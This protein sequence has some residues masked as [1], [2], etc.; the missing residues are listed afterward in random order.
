MIKCVICGQYK[1]ECCFVFTSF[2]MSSTCNDCKNT[3]EAAKR[4]KEASIRVETQ[5]RERQEY[6]KKRKELVKN[7]MYDGQYDWM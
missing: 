4:E 7:Q 6:E 3:A 5:W 2:S 1:S